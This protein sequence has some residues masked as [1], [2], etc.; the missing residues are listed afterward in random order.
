M[1][2]SQIDALPQDMTPMEPITTATELPLAESKA[3]VWNT[4]NL[5]LRTASDAISSFVAATLVA[6]IVTAVD[7]SVFRVIYM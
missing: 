4:K 5:G 1:R 7:K 2:N 3:Q 6:P